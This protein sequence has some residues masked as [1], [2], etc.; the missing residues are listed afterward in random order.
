MYIEYTYP[1]D[2]NYLSN[3]ILGHFLEA[4]D[5]W[6]NAHQIK[7]KSKIIKNKIKITFSDSENYSFFALSFNYQPFSKSELS[8]WTKHFV[9]KEPM[10]VD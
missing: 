5:N 6:A 3:L 7:Y 8:V 4:V 9:F 10:K 1:N 2:R